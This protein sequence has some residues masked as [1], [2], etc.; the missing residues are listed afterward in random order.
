[1]ISKGA[2]LWEVESQNYKSKAIRKIITAMTPD[3]TE[4]ATLVRVSFIKIINNNDPIK[5]T[6][7]NM[8]K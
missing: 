7:V 4:I 6:T 3:E 5:M 8:S 1:M 2:R